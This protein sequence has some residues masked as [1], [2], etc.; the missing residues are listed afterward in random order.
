M[1]ALTELHW[2][3]ASAAARAFAA[4][5]LSPV[6]LVRALL[7]RAAALDPRIKDRKSVV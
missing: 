7:D 5:R 2:L 4:R 1:A 3:T 6:E